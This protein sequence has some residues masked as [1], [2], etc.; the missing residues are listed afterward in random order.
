MGEKRSYAPDPRPAKRI[1]DPAVMKRLHLRGVVCVLCGNKGSLHHIYPKGQGGDDAESNLCAL[2][3][4]GT[5]GHHGLIEDGDVQTRI[6]LGAHLYLDRPDF[7]FYLQAKLGEG[8]AREW[9][10]QKFFLS[11]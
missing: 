1:K 11:V 6:A 3:G 8:A 10:R 5:S 7:M 4:S 9:L 2:C